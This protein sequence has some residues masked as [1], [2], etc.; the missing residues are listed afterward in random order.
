MRAAQASLTVASATFRDLLRRPGLVL[1]A[2]A[3]AALLALLPDICRRALDDS[4][5]LSLQVGITS[6]TLFLTLAAGFAGLRAG[7]A[8]GD[9]GAT[10]EWLTAP[11]SPFA[12]VAGR[13]AGIAAVCATLLFIL[14]LVLVPAQLRDPPQVLPS[15]FALAGALMTAAQFAALGAMLAALVTPQLAAVFLVAAIV[16]S[17]TV[18]PQLDSAGGPAALLAAA[19]P[20]PVRVD[21]SREV[22]FHRPVDAASAAFALLAAALQ[23]AALL[24]VAAFC[25]RRR[26]T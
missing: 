10:P 22:A 3:V 7:A 1:A 23:T 18:V 6:I 14:A 5:A 9:L 26:E 15:A 20:D 11:L 12:Y 21:L 24:V 17:R 25:I 13:F 4:S 19:L 2:I 8:D 16:A